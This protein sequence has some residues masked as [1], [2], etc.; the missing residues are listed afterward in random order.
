[1][2]I[3]RSLVV[4]LLLTACN[5]PHTQNATVQ[6]DTTAAIDSSK[7]PVSMVNNKKDLVCGMPVS[8]G[9]ADTA[10]YNG[11]VYG[12]CSQ[13]CKDQFLKDPAKYAAKDK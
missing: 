7:Y 13:E 10:H 2:K 11:K 5:A 8:A 6:R 4:I 1:M 9:I 12:F 3:L